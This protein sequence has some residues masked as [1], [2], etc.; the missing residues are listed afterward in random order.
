[1]PR[2][3]IEVAY[4]GTHYSGFQVQQNAITIQSVVEA[5]LQILY[6]QPLQLTCSSR[7]DAGVHALQNFYHVDT[8]LPLDKKLYNLN[9]LLPND[10]VIKNIAQ[11]KDHV[12]ARFSGEAREYK[13]FI[14][15]NK[16][17]FLEETAWRY[18]FAL[19]VTILN[20]CAAVL[21]NYNDFTSFSK[22]HTQVNNFNCHIMLSQWIQENGCLV[23]HVKANRFLRGMVRGLVGTMLLAGR[24]NISV[25]DFRKIIEAKDCTKANFSTPAHGLFLVKVTYP[26][27]CFS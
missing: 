26:K 2:Y 25:L 3:F 10:V 20:E 22:K 8:D 23:Y 14:T 12:H 18:A 1:M 21:F 19:D 6:R 24:G 13:Y 11:V 16:N 15:Q 17:P 27:T 7:T 9:A 5:A 4:K